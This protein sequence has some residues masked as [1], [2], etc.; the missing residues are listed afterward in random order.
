[1]N[2]YLIIGGSTGIGHSLVQDLAS[3]GHRVFASFNKNPQSSENPNVSYHKLDVLDESL[4]L[5]FVPDI[6]DGF[7]Y[8]PG[9]VNLKPF[10]RLKPASFTED[11]EFQVT[12]CIRILQEVLPKLKTSSLASVVLFSTVAVKV[13]YNFHSQVAASKGAIEGLT[14]A[15]AAEYAPKVRFNAIAPSITDTPLVAKFLSTEEKIQANAD[16]HPLK[17]IGTAEDISSMASFLLSE[18]AAWITGQIFHIDGGM[19]SVKS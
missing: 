15:L 13:G 14:R 16:R 10:N 8:C 19:S 17:K 3:Q 18:K 9:S 12:G 11:F 5:S 2:T 6:I 4:D 7:V 1:M